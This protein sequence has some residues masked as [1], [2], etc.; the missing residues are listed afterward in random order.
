M[1]AW[2]EYFHPG[3]EVLKNKPGF[4]DP[5]LLERFERAM[6]DLREAQIHL[7]TL[8]IE[9]TY[10]AAHLTAI[11]HALFQDLYD[12]AGHYRTVNLSKRDLIAQQ[13]KNFIHHEDITAVLDTVLTAVRAHPWT[14]L[15]PGRFAADLATASTYL[16][17]AHPFREGNGRA[18]KLLLAHIAEQTPYTLDYDRVSNVQWVR[19]HTVALP[20]TPYQVPDTAGLTRTIERIT[21]PRPDTTLPTTADTGISGPR[22]RK[23]SP[24]PSPPGQTTRSQTPA[25]TAPPPRPS[26]RN[27]PRLRIRRRSGSRASA[28][29][30]PPASPPRPPR[31]RAPARTTPPRPALPGPGLAP[32]GAPTPLWN[33]ENK[34]FEEAPGGCALRSRGRPGLKPR[35][36]SPWSTPTGPVPPRGRGRVL[37]SSGRQKATR[38]AAP[39]DA[40]GRHV[41]VTAT[42]NVMTKAAARR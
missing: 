28:G 42:R 39:G 33:P 40:G 3:T 2:D 1:S 4:T 13:A 25:R 15:P 8:P 37:F 20:E 34:G 21:A 27:R 36:P 19:A 11:H 23:P 16:N 7:G 35:T 29:S 32:R 18:Q 14:T 24:T 9:R 17:Y 12:W 38:H 26:T 41:P 6:T 5:A 10:D 31:N 22:C 30:R